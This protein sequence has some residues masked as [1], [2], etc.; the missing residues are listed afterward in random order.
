MFNKIDKKMQMVYYIKHKRWF[1]EQKISGSYAG[2]T[3][4]FRKYG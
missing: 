1:Y 2:Y 3:K 4:S